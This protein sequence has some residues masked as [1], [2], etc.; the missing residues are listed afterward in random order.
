MKGGSPVLRCGVRALDLTRPR[1]VGVLNIT[2]DSFSDGGSL[3]DGALRSDALAR[4][5]EAMQREGVDILDIGGESTR[6]GAVPVSPQEELDRVLP[7]LERVR[8][9]SDA[10]ISVD[11]STPEVIRQAAAGG[12]ELINDVRALRRPGALEAAA[13]TGAAVCL[14]H[15]RG[16]PQTMQDAPAYPNG[17]IDEVGD[18]LAGRLAACRDAGIASDRILLDPGFGFGKTLE[19]NLTLLSG[20]DRLTGRFAQP[21]MAGLS[22]K[23]ML[24]QIS[25]RS[26]PADR[27]VAGA[28]AVVWALRGGARLVRTHDVG[29]T[30][31]A[32]RMFE[33]LT[34]AGEPA[35]EPPLPMARGAGA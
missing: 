26:A 35:I 14:M 5:V 12:A 6:P 32:I 31:D 34:G 23:S 2:P 1:I 7:A 3:Y 18:F 22:R 30:R 25:G 29:P 19:H 8:A 15:L 27:T 21:W 16:E 28:L 33:A 20:L 13:E 17:V 9:I 11:T 24:G 10:L 4:R